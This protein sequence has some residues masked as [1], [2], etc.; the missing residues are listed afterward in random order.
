MVKRLSIRTTKTASGATA[1]QIV[2][3][4]KHKRIIIKHIGSAGTDEERAVLLDVAKSYLVEHAEQ[5]PLFMPKKPL[6]LLNLDHARVDKITHSFARKFLHD[7]AKKIG[8]N[9]KPLFTDLAI[10]RI[11]EPVSKLRT[12]EL[13]LRYFDVQYSVWTYQSLKHFHKEKKAI[14][15]VAYSAAKNLLNEQFFLVLYDVTTLYFETHKDDDTVRRRGFSKDHKENQP[16]IVV[17]LLVTHS[18]F[19]LA[20]EVF[21]GKTFEGHTMLPMLESFATTHDVSVPIVVADAA[22]ISRDNMTKLQAK[23]ISYIVGARLANSGTEMIEKISTA[24]K[25][26][27]FST[28]RIPSDL[29]DIVC[30]YSDKR[31]RKDK[32]EMDK[33]VEKAKALV[34]NGEAGRRAKYIQKDNKNKVSLNE[35][36]VE[37]NKLLLGIKGYC[38]N[39]PESTLSNE[40]IIAYYHDLWHV[41]QTFRMSKND[42]ETRPIFHYQ[43]EAIRAHVLLC[44]VALMIG[45]FLEI[46]TKLSL[47]SIKDLIWQV[48]DV[49][50]T[51]THNRKQHTLQ[52][53]VAEVEHSPLGRLMQDNEKTH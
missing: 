25:A 12:L 15:Q 50:I 8:L 33:L 40:Q 24:L 27:N 36:L 10:M 47:R 45:R 13:L 29:G 35:T 48:M 3:Y 9:L 32:R 30:D 42:L 44:F 26:A 28:V 7:C 22:M 49:H 19:P 43:E 51:D 17:G 18:G 11:I 34:Q 31:Y 23:E 41:E 2:Q 39:I 5:Q 6:R 37:K 4:Q 16:Q 53:S 52:S 1:V 21:H 20:H 38:T 46:E 14:E